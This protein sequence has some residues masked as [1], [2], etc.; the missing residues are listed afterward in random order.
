MQLMQE[1]NTLDPKT[2]R[3]AMSYMNI[4][5][6][7]LAG[8]E[9]AGGGFSLYGTSPGRVR[10]TAYGIMEFI[11]MKRVYTDVSQDMIDRSARW[12]YKKR[13]G[14]GG[15][16]GTYY[17]WQ[18]Y[19]AT[20]DAYICL[21]LAMHGKFDISKEL[22]K[23]S[24]EAKESKDWYRLSLSAMANQYA[25]N[26]EA[27]N[28]LVNILVGELQNNGF[29]KVKVGNTLMYSYGYSKN[30]ETWA[31]AAQAIMMTNRVND[32]DL[33]DALIQKIASYKSGYG[34]FGSTQSTIQALKALTAYTKFQDDRFANGETGE[35]TIIV[36]GE[37]ASRHVYNENTYGAI[38]TDIHKYLKPGKNTVEVKFN[39]DKLAIPFISELNWYTLKPNSS[40]DCMVELATSLS[41]SEVKVGETVRMK[42]EVKNRE[43]ETVH[44]PI[45]LVG[46]PSGLSLQPWQLKELLDKEKVAY[47][48]INKNFL[49]LYFNYFE[50]SETRTINLDLKAD[51]PG[52][53]KA[54][55]GSAYLYYGAEDKNWQHGVD[56]VVKE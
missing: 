43:K 29:D 34:Y 8:Y 27:A 20:Q 21:A 13:N 7:K 11:D 12:L 22:L 31:V 18:R 5:Y 15:W 1:T 19:A 3:N 23:A 2:R 56:V 6:K 26:N 38:E 14:N 35:M 30:I 16:Y 46:I 37:A 51:I 47:Y 28:E 17:N 33:L 52:K 44:N 40:P 4:A 32:R 48:E 9:S 50:S 45:A 49:V 41:E 39:D 53:Y 25:G 36:N 42:V 10:L 55:A 24:E 54:V